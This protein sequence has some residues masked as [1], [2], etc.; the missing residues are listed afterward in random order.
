M[1]KLVLSG[2]KRYIVGMKKHLAKEHPSTR[3]RM[4]LQDKIEK[5]KHKICDADI[6]EEKHDGYT[7]Y[8]CAKCGAV[9][10]EKNKNMARYCC[11]DRNVDNHNDFSNTK[12]N[13]HWKNGLLN[14]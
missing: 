14:G 13:A 12:H 1:T 3:H 11:E 10:E 5:D 7:V 6:V 9:Y 2:K 4:K 8:R